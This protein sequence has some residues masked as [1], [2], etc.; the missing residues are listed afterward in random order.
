[1]VLVVFRSRELHEGLKRFPP[2]STYRVLHPDFEGYWQFFGRIDVGEGCF[3]H[4]ARAAPTPT[5]DNFDFH[6]PAPRRRLRFRMRV[7]LR[8]FWELRNRGGRAL[9]ASAAFSSLAMPRTAIRL[10]AASA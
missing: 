10:T 6:G 8:G 7:R 1:M 2:R 3:F 4:C 5:R 9:S